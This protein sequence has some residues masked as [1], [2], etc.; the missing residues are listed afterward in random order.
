MDEPKHYRLVKSDSTALLQSLVNNMIGKGWRP[1]G[2]L[3]IL[4]EST[5]YRAV[6]IQPMT[7]WDIR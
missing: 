6:Y 2:P 7:K 3:A 1:E 4:Q 5:E